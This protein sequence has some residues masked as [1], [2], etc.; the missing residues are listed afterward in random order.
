MAIPVNEF[1]SR[2]MLSVMRQEPKNTTFLSSMFVGQRTTHSTKNI[3]L[4][5]V[6]GNRL[7]AR[8]TNRHGD[9]AK[10]GRTGFSNIPFVAPYTYEE[11]EFSPS[12]LDDR[13]PGRTEWDV[14]PE[15][16][17]AV[18]IDG[19][20]ENLNTRLDVLEEKQVAEVL[21]TGELVVA[22]KGVS[23]TIDYGM[24]AGNKP[25]L[26]GGDRWSE[27]STRDIL[28]DL[29]SWADIIEDAGA[30]TPGMVIGDRVSMG[31]V[32]ADATI[33]AYLD[34]RRIEIGMLAPRYNPEQR[35]TFIGTL[36]YP[37]LSLQ[38]WSYHGTYDYIDGSGDKQSARF[39]NANTVVMTSSSMNFSYEYGKIENFNA[40]GFRG[41][42]F[43]SYVEAPNGKTRSIMMESSPLPGFNQPDAVVAA[44]VA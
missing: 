43:P 11:Y 13:L 18:F 24:A 20:L 3:N 34:N 15:E 5:R 12:D 6:F 27:A 30:P 19:A 41:A 8:Y 26:T 17:A 22:G 36:N 31:Y 25:T 37:G 40:P 28:G 10:L 4:D 35:A 38:L 9:P 16:N 39:M 23:Y 44:T 42:R 7:T 21:Q 2:D 14:D 29:Q 33:Q 1:T 32:L